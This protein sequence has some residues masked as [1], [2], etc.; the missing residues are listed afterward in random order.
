SYKRASRPGQSE[1]NGRC[2]DGNLNI[3]GF[4][5]TM[6]QQQTPS[7]TRIMALRFAEREHQA[8][9]NGEWVAAGPANAIPIVNPATGEQIGA[10]AAAAEREIDMAVVAAQQ[11]LTKAERNGWKPSERS[12]LLWALADAIEAN[13][14]ELAELESLDVGKPIVNAQRVDVPGAAAALR[15]FAGWAGKIGGETVELSVPGRW[16]AYSRREPVGVVGQIVPWNYPLMGAA[17]KIA[18]A[19]AAGCA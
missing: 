19:I 6:S 8:F 2:I 18:P 13:A 11:A 9:I 12:R 17:C 15:Y 1:P 5:H 7:Q 14:A 10:L 4:D 3:T 16:H